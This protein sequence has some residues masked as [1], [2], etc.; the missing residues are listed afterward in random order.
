MRNS[1]RFLAL[2]L[3]VVTAPGVARAQIYY[4]GPYTDPSSHGNVYYVGPGSTVLGDYGRG[5]GLFF[6]GLGRHNMYNAQS[7]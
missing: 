6:D 1:I 4:G 2:A 7:L 3:L 5:A